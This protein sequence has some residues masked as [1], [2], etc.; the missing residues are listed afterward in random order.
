MIYLGGGSWCKRRNTWSNE[1]L[2]KSEEQMAAA[3]FY[4]SCTYIYIYICLYKE[5][6]KVG[7]K[8]KH[9]QNVNKSPNLDHQKKKCK[10]STSTTSILTERW[11]HVGRN[12]GKRRLSSDGSATGTMQVLRNPSVVRTS[13][14]SCGAS[15]VFC[16]FSKKWILLLSKEKNTNPKNKF[17]PLG[18]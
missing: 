16:Y 10:L 12:S 7:W 18:D 1:T 15:G 2:T 17:E 8:K 5:T 14:S 13:T 3:P 11:R 4:N 9:S 6:S